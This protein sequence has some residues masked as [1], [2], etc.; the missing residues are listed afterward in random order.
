MLA[1][2]DRRGLRR[3]DRQNLR[4]ALFLD[5]DGTLRE[6]VRDP[7]AAAPTPELRDLLERLGASPKVAVTII[8][9]R[10]PE[11][12]ER[13]LGEYRRFGMIAEHGAAVRRPGSGEWEQLDRNVSYRWK[14]E[15]API[16]R[17]YEE[18]TPGSFVEEKRTSLVWHFRRSDPEFGEWKAR[19]LV[20]ELEAVIA[21]QP[22]GARLGRKIV[23][24]TA[25]QVNKGAAVARLLEGQGP[26][27]L[28]LVA[29]DD[30]TDES[31]YQL[32]LRNLIPINVGQRQTHAQCI[33]PDPA[34]LRRLLIESLPA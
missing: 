14:E 25:T 27:E 20:D 19:Q 18:A 28:V 16:L 1:A 21:N 13:F 3:C 31:M 33:L 6:I 2:P 12:L 7:A 15:V 24:V 10:T 32:E 29:G 30:V 17:N 9:G 4:I 34:A 8:S 11:D 26:F 5:Y 23:E 22:L